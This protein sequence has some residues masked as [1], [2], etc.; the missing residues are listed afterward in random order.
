MTPIG[1]PGFGNRLF[2][3]RGHPIEFRPAVAGVRSTSPALVDAGILDTI[4]DFQPCADGHMTDGGDT[5]EHRPLC[6]VDIVQQ[7]DPCQ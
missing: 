2:I 5:E 6:R 7:V 3:Q 4:G 1:F